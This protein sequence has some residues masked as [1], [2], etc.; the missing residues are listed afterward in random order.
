MA[1]FFSR[2]GRF[3]VTFRMLLRGVANST[4]T[5]RALLNKIYACNKHKALMLYNRYNSHYIWQCKSR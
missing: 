3:Y 2:T 1:I 5:F 4:K